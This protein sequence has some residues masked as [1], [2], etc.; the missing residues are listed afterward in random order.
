MYCIV[1]NIHLSV[2]MN[3]IIM[4]K[5]FTIYNL[6]VYYILICSSIFYQLINNYKLKKQKIINLSLMT[7]GFYFT[8]QTYFVEVTICLCIV[9]LVFTF[10]K[11]LLIT[12]RL[13]GIIVIIIQCLML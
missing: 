11:A 8:C 6:N 1:T 10:S 12:K 2:V 13:D 7:M 4:I 9:L 3:P 5:I